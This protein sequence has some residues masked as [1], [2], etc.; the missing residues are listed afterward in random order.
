MFGDNLH[1]GFIVCYDLI[2]RI[3]IDS[4]EKARQRTFPAEMADKSKL[5]NVTYRQ[6]VLKRTRELMRINAGKASE[7][8]G[9]PENAQNIEFENTEIRGN[10]PSTNVVIAAAKK[11]KRGCAGK[12]AQ[13]G[14]IEPQLAQGET[15]GALW[16]KISNME[17]EKRQYEKEHTDILSNIVLN[18]AKL[19][20][21]NRKRSEIQPKHDLCVNQELPPVE[22]DS[23]S[24]IVDNSDEGSDDTFM[25]EFEGLYEENK[26]FGPVIDDKLSQLFNRAIDKAMPDDQQKDLS[27]KY[28]VPANCERLEVPVVN[29]ELWTALK[30]KREGDLAM[31]TVQKYLKLAMVPNLMALEILKNKGDQ[32]KLPQ[33]I[34]DSFKIIANGLHH[35][36]RKRKALIKPGLPV[37]YRKVCDVDTPVTR[38]LFGDDIEAKV[39]EIEKEE[40]RS[41]KL[42]GVNTGHFLHQKTAQRGSRSYQ[43]QPYKHLSEN[44]QTKSHIQVFKKNKGQSFRGK[45]STQSF[46][47]KKQF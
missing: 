6:R 22:M 30:E 2:D 26:K 32:T 10:S 25:H 17:S 47:G 21:Q 8:P 35:C 19:Q 4:G 14:I 36:N 18:V 11:R 34:K 13:T 41:Q 20:Q 43:H 7:S 33:L 46:R 1:S 44:G 31:Q 24:D 37:K 12:P 27:D 9:N 42:S 29:K 45:S 38:N 3:L 15:F 16:E 28:L 40:R 23:V 5:R 39:D